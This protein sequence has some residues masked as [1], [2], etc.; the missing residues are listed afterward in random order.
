MATHSSILA[1]RIPWTEESA[2]LQS[3]GLQKCQSW[4]KRLSTYHALH[5]K[6]WDIQGKIKGTRCCSS[7][8]LVSSVAQ[9]VSDSLRPHEPQHIRPPCP[10]PTPRV[11]LNSCPLSPWCHP[12]IS[13][14]IVPFSSQLHLSQHQVLF[15]WV[16]SSHQVAK[17]LEFQ[18]QNQ[19]QSLRWIFSTDLL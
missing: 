3:M 8:R 10:S 15:K 1:W 18:L 13:S 9:V 6:L 12:T 19:H 2:G 11:Y 4:L 16:S 5:T 14:S 7:F 17:V